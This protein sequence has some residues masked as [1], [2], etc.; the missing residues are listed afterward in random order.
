MARKKKA[1]FGVDNHGSICILHL[2][3]KAAQEWA[4]EYLPEDRMTW[5]ANG[6]IVEPRY[7]QPIVDGLIAEGFTYD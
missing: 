6:V 4:D 3:S 1:D 7:V 2:Y 5:G